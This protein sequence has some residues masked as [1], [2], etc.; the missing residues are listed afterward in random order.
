MGNDPVIAAVREVR[1]RISESVDHDPYR[2]VAY[3]RQRQERRERP[4]H[5]QQT[6]EPLQKSKNASAARA[7]M[8]CEAVP[9]GSC[10]ICAS[11][12]GR[13]T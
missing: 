4:T 1:H 9:S 7:G 6:A 11:S 13:S 8:K 12:A 3:Y 10:R 5:G 2:L